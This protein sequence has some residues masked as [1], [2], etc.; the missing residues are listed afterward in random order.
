MK[1]IK[2]TNKQVELYNSGT[3]V[4]VRSIGSKGAVDA[5]LSSDE[6][7]IVITYENGSAEI[8]N[9]ETNAHRATPAKSKAVRASFQG[10]RVLVTLDNGKIELRSQDGGHITT[11]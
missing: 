2:I 10:D 9:V 7:L 11:Y 4:R 3:G 5:A 8:Y 6:K 1:I